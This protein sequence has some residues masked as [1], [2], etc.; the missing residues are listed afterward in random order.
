MGRTVCQAVIDDPEMELVAAIDP[1]FAGIDLRQLTG[2]ESAGIQISSGAIELE[3]AK[4]E[5]V[6]DFTVAEA[7]VEN[8]KWCA[9]SGIHAVVGTTGLS[10]EELEELRGAFDTSSANCVVAANFAIGAVLMARFAELAAPFM[11]G[12]EIIELHHD[13]KADAPSGTALHVA[14]LIAD[15]R[16][17]STGTP[18]SSD[19]TTISPV[20][21]TRG[22]EGPGGLRVHSIRLPGLVAHHEVIFGA[23][24]QTLAIRHDAFDRTS[25]MPGVLLA[26][27]SVAGAEGLTVGLG[28]LLGF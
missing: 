13:N 15:A 19:P 23:V 12:V 5:V 27:R 17:R 14:K 22:G 20:V 10:S 2:V 6:V 18:F 1:E 26:V 11:E 28:P 16:A 4:A 24:G 21:G 8:M 7:A 25:F 3:R 9:S